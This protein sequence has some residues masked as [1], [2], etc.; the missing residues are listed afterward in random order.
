MIFASAIITP[1]TLLPPMFS[2]DVFL[3]M[4]EEADLPAMQAQHF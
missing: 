3:F 1:V 4:I 2:A